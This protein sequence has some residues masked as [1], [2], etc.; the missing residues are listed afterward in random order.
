M[1]DT[2]N[3]SIKRVE[4]HEIKDDIFHARLIIT[5]GEFTGEKPLVLDSRPSDALAL[6]TR[7]RCPIYIASSVIEETGIPLDYFTEVEDDDKYRSLREQLEAAIAEE[8][9][10]QA[11]EIRD[12]LKILKDDPLQD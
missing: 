7:K 9:Y 11:A 4:I 10:E 8:E 5:G 12:L 1:L 3:L 2:V 6:A